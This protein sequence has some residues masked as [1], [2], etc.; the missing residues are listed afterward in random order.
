VAEGFIFIL[1][2]PQNGQ[3]K[4]ISSYIAANTA[5]ILFINHISPNNLLV[6]CGLLNL[7]RTDNLWL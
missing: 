7:N 1:F 5:N 6:V 2:L 3:N 4:V